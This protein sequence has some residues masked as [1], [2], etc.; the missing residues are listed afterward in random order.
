MRPVDFSVQGQHERDG[1]F[2]DC[3][4]GVVRDTNQL[5]AHLI[6]TV[7]IDVVKAGA[8]QRHELCLLFRKGN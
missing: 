6:G 2:C 3:I 8:A 7:D 4:R 1:M 5:D